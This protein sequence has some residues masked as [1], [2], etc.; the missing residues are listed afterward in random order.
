MRPDVLVGPSEWVVEQFGDKVAAEIWT[1]VPEALSTAI[2]REVNARPAT[3]QAAER[4]LANPRWPLPYEELV[5]FL[6][7]LPGAEIISVPKSVYQLVLIN[8]HV[9]VPWCYGQSA[10]VSMGDAEVG[11]SF[12]RLVRELL[13][14]FG[15]P[16]RRSQTESP[17][18]LDAVDEREV[19]KICAAI[20]RIEP[21]PDVVVAGYAGAPNLGLLRACLGEIK[22]T[23]NG[24][25]NWN[26][27][28]DLPLPPPVIPRP[29]RMHF[30]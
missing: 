2:E 24:T 21:R 16:W 11:R 8:G 6:G 5:L 23:D 17:L 3:A 10:R 9:L 29:R 18:P 26:H 15:P 14:R 30:P 4:V 25:L 19:A 28:A 22:S 27:V 13:R 1:R 12:G 20:C 7:T